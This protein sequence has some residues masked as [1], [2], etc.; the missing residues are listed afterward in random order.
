MN[1]LLKGLALKVANEMPAGFLWEEDCRYE[2]GITKE[3]LFEFIDRLVVSVDEEV[4]KL[5]QDA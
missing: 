1:L 3:E 2:S 4:K 5:K